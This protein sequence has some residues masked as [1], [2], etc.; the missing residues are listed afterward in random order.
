[1]HT[2]TGKMARHGLAAKCSLL[3]R[4][5][6]Y[7]M[8]IPILLAAVVLG[9]ALLFPALSPIGRKILLVAAV[10]PVIFCLYYM[11]VIP[12]WRP[13]PSRITQKARLAIFVCVAMGVAAGVVMLVLS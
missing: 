13:H 11:I 10:F 8:E 6:G 4:Q 1:M 2:V 3:Q 7:L 5:Q 12:G 9:V